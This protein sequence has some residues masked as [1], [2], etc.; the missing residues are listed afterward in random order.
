MNGFAVDCVDDVVVGGGVIGLAHAYQLARRGRRVAVLERHARALGASVRNFGMLWPIGQP[1]GSLRD[2]AMRSRDIWS[3]VLAASGLWHDRVGSLHVAY[4]DDE[5]CVLEEFAVE[6]ADSGFA[7][8]LLDVSA[9]CR[10]SPLLRR[11]GLR[12]ALFSPNEICIDPQVTMRRL[13]SWLSTWH[14]VRFEFGVQVTAC[15]PPWVVA[16]G[17]HWHAKRIWLCTGADLQTLFPDTLRQQGLVR[18]KLQMMRSAPF[19]LR[20]GPM[21]AGGLTLLHY[22][23]FD[24]CRTRSALQCR[25]DREL[26]EH[27]EYGIHVMASQHADGALTIGD[28]H[29][30]GDDIEPFDASRINRLVLEYLNRFLHAPTEIASHWHGCYVKHPVKAWVEEA[31]VDRVVLVTGLG[32]HGMTMAFGVAEDVVRRALD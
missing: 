8:Q 18:C 14:G 2:M 16:S 7:C 17:R 26:P 28:S 30:Y 25:L 27:R 1:A 24:A 19:G 21:L 23:S 12:L 6:A 3:E 20:I 32:G 4:K 13:P 31:P 29:Q 15:E 5:A 10:R 11:E 22:R 9:A